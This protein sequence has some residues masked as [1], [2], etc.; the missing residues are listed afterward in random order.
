MLYK[1]N[2]GSAQHWQAVPWALNIK[3]HLR[4][5]LLRGIKKLREK[6]GFKSSIL[7]MVEKCTQYKFKLSANIECLR[8]YAGW[9]YHRPTLS[10]KVEVAASLERGRFQP[11]RSKTH[12]HLSRW[13][14]RFS[15]NSRLDVLVG[16]NLVGRM[17][18]RKKRKHEEYRM[19]DIWEDILGS[20]RIRTPYKEEQCF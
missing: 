9:R 17:R 2:Q 1:N 16:L 13:P 7:I 20:Q 19:K 8:P 5:E 10:D 14:G 3:N 11:K 15:L 6:I 4:K 12:L 18:M